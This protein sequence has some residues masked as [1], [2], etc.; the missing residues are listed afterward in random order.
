MILDH[1]KIVTFNL[2][3]KNSKKNFKKLKNLVCKVHFVRKYIE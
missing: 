1:L 3:T 2:S